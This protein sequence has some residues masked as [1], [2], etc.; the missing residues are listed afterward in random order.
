MLSH[1]AGGIV[2]GYKFP[3]KQLEPRAS[4]IFILFAPEIPSLSIY[5]KEVEMWTKIYDQ[6]VS[7]LKIKN[8]LQGPTL[9]EYGMVT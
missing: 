8:H 4:K 6:R 1:I 9:E 7:K 2:N 3:G 5:I